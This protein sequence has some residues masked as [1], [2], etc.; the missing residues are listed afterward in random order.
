MS[1]SQGLRTVWVKQV[2]KSGYALA[3]QN[4]VPSLI[5]L[6]GTPSSVLKN[7]VV[8]VYNNQLLDPRK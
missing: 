5:R 8:S 1:H 6:A 7:T 3:T 2:A 4:G